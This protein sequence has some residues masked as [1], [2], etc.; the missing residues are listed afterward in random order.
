LKNNWTLQLPHKGDSGGP[1]MAKEGDQTVIIATVSF[2]RGC[3]LKGFPGVYCTITPKLRW[4]ESVIGEKL[5][6]SD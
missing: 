2:G 3:A 1:L 6:H 4:I 5:P